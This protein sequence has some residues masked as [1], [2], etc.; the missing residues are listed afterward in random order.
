MFIENAQV[1]ITCITSISGWME[2]Y[3]NLNICLTWFHFHV[4][5]L[6]TLE[7]KSI[8]HLAYSTLRIDI[9]YFQVFF[10]YFGIFF[11]WNLH[12]CFHID[13]THIH[14]YKKNIFTSSH[15]FTYANNIY[16]HV[17]ALHI[18]FHICMKHLQACEQTAILTFSF[19]HAF[20]YAHLHYCY[21]TFPHISLISSSLLSH[22]PNLVKWHDLLISLPSCY[23]VIVTC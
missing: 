9:T 10:T 18:Y 7:A 17:C 4:I 13:M 6:H 14:C 20:V 5:G 21:T 12:L 2:W 1:S 19:A 16:I 15:T 11:K 23:S 8:A 3:T 22:F